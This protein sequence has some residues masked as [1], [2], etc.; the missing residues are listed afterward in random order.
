MIDKAQIIKLIEEKL[1]GTDIFLVEVKL[2][3]GKLTVLLDKPSGIQLKECIEVN[4]FL[5]SYFETTD[6]LEKH[7]LEVSSPG[8]DQPLKVLK[9][10]QRRIGRE[11]SVI[12]IDG[13]LHKGKLHAASNEGIEITSV[14]TNKINKKKEITEESVHIPFEIIKETK[15]I[16]NI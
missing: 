2:S 9:Q 15:L 5:N 16:I 6:F 10:Y 3:P 8:M 12:T 1:A 13:Q 4:R 14:K 7:E 11:I